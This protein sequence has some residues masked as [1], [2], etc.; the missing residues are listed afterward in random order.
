MSQSARGVQQGGP[1]SNPGLPRV[2]WGA[3]IGT[4]GDNQYTDN[5]IGAQPVN[6][7]RQ[8]P[9]GTFSAP[10]LPGSAWGAN[11]G[12]AGDGIRSD[13]NPGYYRNNQNNQQ[14]IQNQIQLQ[15]KYAPPTPIQQMI[16]SS[17]GGPLKYDG[18]HVNY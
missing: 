4:A 3:N 17:G 5:K 18:G 16:Q 10:R 1:Q 11:I 8:Q 12:T 9:G 2:P 6:Q 14:F 15:Q 7:R 13:M